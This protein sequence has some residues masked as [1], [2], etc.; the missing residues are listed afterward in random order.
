[1][2]TIFCKPN[3]ISKHTIIE[4]YPNPQIKKCI[5]SEGNEYTLHII[6]S[7]D[8]LEIQPLTKADALYYCG[9]TD[10][11]T[12][13]TLNWFP[14]DLVVGVVDKFY[15]AKSKLSIL[16][17]FVQSSGNTGTR[18]ECF[19]TEKVGIAIEKIWGVGFDI[20]II[21]SAENDVTKRWNEKLEKVGF[22]NAIIDFGINEALTITGFINMKNPTGRVIKAD[23]K[24]FESG[25]KI[26][27]TADFKKTIQRFKEKYS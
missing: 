11:I 16:T 4:S 7:K 5:D 9:R 1:M 26:K 21:K 25:V 8:K 14:K 12:M 6:L 24:K 3:E 23:F 19:L 27:I 20:D 2:K 22:E 10:E 15:T 13:L 17:G 18:S